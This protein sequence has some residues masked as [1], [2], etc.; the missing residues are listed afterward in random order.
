V[1]TRADHEQ[2]DLV[3]E[4]GELGGGQ[5]YPDHAIDARQ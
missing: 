3:C 1:A 4:R 2:V 5:P